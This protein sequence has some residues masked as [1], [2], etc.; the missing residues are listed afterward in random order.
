MPTF[1]KRRPVFLIGFAFFFVFLNA[2]A[3]QTDVIKISLRDA[4]I[5]IE[6][7]FEVKF[8]YQD[9]IV[10]GKIIDQI[11]SFQNLNQAL[12]FLRTQTKLT[13]QLL[14]DRFVAVTNPSKV[15]RIC[16][17]LKNI[18]TNEVLFGASVTVVAMDKGVTTDEKGFFVLNNLPGDGS[19]KISFVGYESIEIPI[20]QLNINN[21]CAPI[22]MIPYIQELEEVVV[23]NVFSRGISEKLD[24][25]IKLTPKE[26]GIL[27]GLSEPDVLQTIQALPGIESVNETI[28]NINIRGGTHDQNLILWDGIKMYHTGHFFGLISAFNPYL[29]EKVSVVKNGTSAYYNDGVSSLISMET[30][31]RLAEKF[32]G[33]GGFNLISADAFARIPINKKLTAQISARRSVIDYFNTPTFEQFFQRSFQDTEIIN[34]ANSENIENQQITGNENFLFYDFAAKLLFDASEKDQL[35]LSAINV[36]NELSYDEFGT[37]EDQT[38][39]SSLDQANLGIG[40]K[41]L[42]RW[43][44]KFTTIVSGYLSKYSIEAVNNDVETNQILEQKNEVLETGGKLTGLFQLNENTSLKGG[45]QFYE[46][47][48]TNAVNVINPDFFRDTKGVIRNHAVFTEATWQKSNTYIRAGLRANYVPKFSRLLIE[49]RVNFRQELG[50]NW[51]LKAL[52]EF[53][54]QYISQV[55]DLQEDFLG[56]DKRRWLLANEEDTPIITSMQGSAGIQYKKNGWLISSEA[57]YKKV[58]DISSRSQG[59]QDQNQ[60]VNTTGGYNVTGTEFL[61]NKRNDSYSIWFTY[62]LAKNTYTFEGLNPSTFPNN[63]DI[64]HSISFAGSYNY[65]KLKLS[66]GLNYRSGTPFTLPDSGDPVN[67]ETVPFEI[68]YAMPNGAN[69]E[70]Y[71]RADFSAIYDFQL[72]DKLPASVGVSVLNILN[73]ENLINSYFRLDENNELQR[74][75]SRSLGLTPN[76]SLRVNF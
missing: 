23:M 60:E 28:S 62:T 9:A 8:S 12:N 16:G 4:F 5:Q 40:G 42:R 48:V 35:R 17:I 76:M 21:K 46:L 32:S 13:Y 7:S 3:Q 22:F 53:K 29:T 74:L 61:I 11:S 57:Y 59:F 72:T 31:D 10:N 24:G 44:T 54:S 18:N 52:G 20:N 38:R 70:D 43:N 69:L 34:E 39:T 49:P 65:K 25:A 71:L 67:E 19:I 36:N 64:R 73:K 55:I 2:F 47:G 14:D 66:V 1:N 68:N 27:P 26:F 6:N 58:D 37:E 15:D 50:K 75:D 56:I 33:G 30:S 45:Y 41:W 63:S 51:T